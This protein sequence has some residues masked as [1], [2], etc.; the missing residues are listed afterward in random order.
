MIRWSNREYA[1]GP[2]TVA[3]GDWLL[4]RAGVIGKV[5]AR[6]GQR[7]ELIECVLAAAKL[8]TRAHGCHMYLVSR[9]T[10]DP[11][12]IWITEAWRSKAYHEAW[13]ARPEIQELMEETSELI[14]ATSEPIL[15]IPVGGKGL[16]ARRAVR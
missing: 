7:E 8:L 16:A 11:D 9:S 5:T 2:T 15:T 3:T 4:S 6:P 12:E 14:A 13:L 10:T 1:L